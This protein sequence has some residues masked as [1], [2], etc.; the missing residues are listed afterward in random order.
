[1]LL[2]WISGHVFT[3]Q[4]LRPAPATGLDARGSKLVDTRSDPHPGLPGSLSTAREAGSRAREPVC[5]PGLR[6]RPGF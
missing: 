2:A 1:M 5:E 3:A 6:S 4:A